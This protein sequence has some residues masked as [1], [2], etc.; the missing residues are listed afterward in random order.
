MHESCVNCGIPIDAKPF[1]DSSIAPLPGTNAELVVARFALPPQYCGMLRYFSQFW[2]RFAR[3]PGEVA[4][5]GLRW[6]LYVNRRPLHPYHALQ[7]IVNPWGEGP[8]P[9]TL[10]LD[11]SAVIELVVANRGVRL[12]ESETDAPPLV[13]GRLLGWYWYDPVHGDALRGG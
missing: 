8:F 4:T 7:H 6:T 1:D 9:I 2:E 10:R 11:A 3:N 5:P 13:G 12:L